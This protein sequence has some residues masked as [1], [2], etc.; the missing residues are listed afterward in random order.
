[1]NY[2]DYEFQNAKEKIE[3]LTSYG[4]PVFVMEPLRGGR[5][6]TL[7]K[8][9]DQ[10]L[11]ERFPDMPLH[12][13]AFRF[14]QSIDQVSVTLSGM[15]SMAQLKENIDI[16]DSER[17]LSDEDMKDILSIAKEMTS[18]GTVP[19]TACRYCTEKCPA[20]LDIP[21]LIGYYNEHSF[22]GG[23]FIVPSAI[24]ALKRNERPTACIGC[25]SCETVCPQGIKVSEVLAD[26][27]EKIGKKIN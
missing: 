8:P 1:M 7:M 16:F 15:S 11:K 17:R 2:I 12:E 10:K 26:L 22:S 24:A 6:V 25:R 14:V 5:L 9:F 4:L 23:G 27:C 13:L 3:L 20:G 19:C 18:V 21:K